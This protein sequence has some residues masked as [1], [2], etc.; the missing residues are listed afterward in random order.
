VPGLKGVQGVVPGAQV[1]PRRTL[2]Q[3]L[4]GAGVAHLQAVGLEGHEG[5]EGVG[6]LC[7]TAGHRLGQR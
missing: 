1:E 7:E 3:G 2:A 4:G 6:V 5:H